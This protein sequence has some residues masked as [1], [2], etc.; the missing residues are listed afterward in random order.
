MYLYK[1]VTYHN[2][3]G[4]VTVP[5]NNTT[6]NSDFVANRKASAVKVDEMV[7]SETTFVTD[8]SYSAFKT[9]VTN[10]TTWASVKYITGTK[11]YQMFLISSSPLS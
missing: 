6:D 10:N 11:S 2:T 8:L 7:L 3:N 5:A 1:T 9:L 4:V